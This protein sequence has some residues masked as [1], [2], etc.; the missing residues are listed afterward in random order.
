MLIQRLLIKIKK[1]IKIIFR[2]SL[3][4][5]NQIPS[6]IE[7]LCFIDDEFSSV[8]KRLLKRFNIK[9]NVNF[10]KFIVNAKNAVPTLT[11]SELGITNNSNISV[12]QQSFTHIEISLKDEEYSSDKTTVIFKTTQG[13]TSTM[14]LPSNISIGL[15]IQ[16][17]LIRVGK[18]I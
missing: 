6:Q 18:K 9:G 7:Q 1:I 15:A 10:L 4:D 14:F 3:F 13:S 11:L 2:F 16:K 8:Q 5:Q 17:Y 12:I